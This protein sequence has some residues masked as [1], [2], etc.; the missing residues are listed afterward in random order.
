[1][2]LNSQPNVLSAKITLEIDK[3]EKIQ[4]VLN[5]VTDLALD[6]QNEKFDSSALD[7]LTDNI[8][9]TMRQNTSIDR[10]TVSN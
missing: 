9:A 5:V 8:I 4:K 2:N 7:D 3:D 10:A 1:M 6:I